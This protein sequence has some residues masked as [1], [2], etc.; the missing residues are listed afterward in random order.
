MGNK[1]IWYLEDGGDML[2][3]F[4]TKGKAISELRFWSNGRFEILT[5]LRTINRMDGEAESINIKWNSGSYTS[6]YLG[7]KYLD[8]LAL[9]LTAEGI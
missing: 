7:K 9:I 1:V 5:D 8:N 4:S 2:G 6:L 3:V